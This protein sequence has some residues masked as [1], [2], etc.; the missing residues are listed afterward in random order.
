MFMPK[1]T[2]A[3]LRLTPGDRVMNEPLDVNM[4]VS[5]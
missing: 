5:F 3:R 2:G 4:N 1:K